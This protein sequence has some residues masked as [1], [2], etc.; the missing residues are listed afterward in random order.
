MLSEGPTPGHANEP[1]HTPVQSLQLVQNACIV[2]HTRGGGRSQRRENANG[3]GR[4][5]GRAFRFHNPVQQQRVS[6]VNERVYMGVIR[7]HDQLEGKRKYSLL[8]M[9]RFRNNLRR[10]SFFLHVAS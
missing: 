2:S 3:T 4:G 8:Y 7:G 10:I 1:G 5:K 6:V 9:N